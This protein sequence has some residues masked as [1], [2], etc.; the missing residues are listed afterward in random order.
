MLTPHSESSQDD[1]HLYNAL[2]LTKECVRLGRLLGKKADAPFPGEGKNGPTPKEPTRA[3]AI[4][5]PLGP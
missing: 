5:C 1:N 2:V 3:A 4:N